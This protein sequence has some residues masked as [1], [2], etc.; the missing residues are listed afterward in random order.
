M[1]T[2]LNFMLTHSTMSKIAIWIF[3]LTVLIIGVLNII[4]VHPF[5]GVVF[6]FLSLNYLPL[7]NTLVKKNLGFSFP[8]L[9]KLILALFIL[10]FTLGVND[11]GKMID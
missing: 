3:A 5:P 10:Q 11:L 1:K 7:A 6:L 8:P 2:Y 9:V 4:L